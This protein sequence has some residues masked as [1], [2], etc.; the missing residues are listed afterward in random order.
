MFD[1]I[2]I[3]I[4]F[5]YLSLQ[6]NMTYLFSLFRLAAPFYYA[7][8]V[9]QP[10]TTMMML[11]NRILPRNKEGCKVSSQ[12]KRTIYLYDTPCCLK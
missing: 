4:V 10:S 3:Q 1:Y 7:K 11:Q 5:Y 12:Y 6:S 2:S 9:T 8:Y